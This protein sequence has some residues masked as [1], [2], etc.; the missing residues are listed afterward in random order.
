MIDV[1]AMAG[2]SPCTDTPRHAVDVLH[3]DH[4]PPSIIGVSG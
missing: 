1:V 3:G 4:G 2:R